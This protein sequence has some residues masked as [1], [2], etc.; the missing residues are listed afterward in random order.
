MAN[1]NHEED[2]SLTLKRVAKN[3]Q[4]QP[5][6]L[7]KQPSDQFFFEQRENL[8]THD[9]SES[10]NLLLKLIKNGDTEKIAE[11]LSNPDPSLRVGKMSA[12]PLRQARYSFVVL[13]TLIS[14]LAIEGGIDSE[15]A[16]NLSDLYIQKM[17]LLTTSQEIAEITYSMIYD[18][19]SRI[20]LLRYPAE[21]TQL[22]RMTIDY[23]LGHLHYPIRI[24]E[25]ANYAS[26]SKNYLS[27]KFHQNT[28][29]TITDFILEARLK[30][31]AELLRFTQQTIQEISMSVGFSSP[32]YFAS[33]FKKI[34]QISPKK[35]RE[36]FQ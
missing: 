26:V 3:F 4:F 16:Y 5:I 33:R 15:S 36:R 27:T 14:R 17:D 18:Y 24:E 25:L 30:E 11:V 21:Y 12:D 20:N 13:V 28:G 31:A 2:F 34:Y 7:D 8:N 6:K 19:T 22:T 32:S 10:F 1:I 9:Y 35:Y 29:I 23:I